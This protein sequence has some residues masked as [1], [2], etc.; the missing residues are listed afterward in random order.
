[1]SAENI[2]IFNALK[3]Y[4]KQIR[5]SR[6]LKRKNVVAADMCSDKLK[7]LEGEEHQETDID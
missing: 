2:H 3:A 6:I 4:G 1:M 7:S 5:L